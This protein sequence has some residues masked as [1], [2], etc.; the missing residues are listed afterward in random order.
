M[1]LTGRS[2]LA[3]V[4]EFSFL[5]DH[6]NLQPVPDVAEMPFLPSV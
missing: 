1:L 3:V 5:I 6:D 2:G 4:A